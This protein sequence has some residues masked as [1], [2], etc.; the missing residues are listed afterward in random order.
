M[1]E[2]FFK[3]KDLCR[4][5]QVHYFSSN[6]SLYGD[7]SER[8]M[9]ILEHDCPDIEV[10]SIDEAFIRLDNMPVDPF[11][12][13]T[14]LRAKIL[15]WTGIPVSI[16]IASTKTLAKVAGDIAKKRTQNGVYSLLDKTLDDPILGTFPIN[17]IWGIGRKSG[18]KLNQMQVNTVAD[19]CKL[20][21]FLVKK[22]LTV[23]GE[24]IQRE[25]QGRHCHD[26]E[27]PTARKNITS[28]RSF[29]TPV[30]ELEQLQEA[31]ANHAVKACVKL[32]QQGSRAR[33]LHV[34]LRTNH[35]K[36]NTPQ[37]ANHV[38]IQ[39][40]HPTSDSAQMIETAKHAI[41][42]IYKANYAYQKCGVTLIDLVDDTHLQ[43]DLFSSID[44]TQ[45]DERMRLIDTLNAKLG[46]NTVFYAA[47]GIRRDWQMKSEHRSQ[48]YTT[49]WSDLLTIE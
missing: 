13:C 41:A 46:N 17:D 29:G 2:P 21:P 16:G 32:R 36:P 27:A 15:Q 18:A 31:V 45:S 23:Q 8:V 25:L 49:A 6:Y 12:F 42:S 10:Y 11:D 20:P 43:Q 14:A 34:F 22:F 9:R 37:Y 44:Y 48:C 28:S 4:R 7:M 30:R 33:A 1:G 35:F 26:L 47:Q 39:F 5:Q 40:L 24:R 19:F 38:T 3:V